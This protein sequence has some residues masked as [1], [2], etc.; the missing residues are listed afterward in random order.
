MT[1]NS[2]YELDRS[3]LYLCEI[4]IKCNVFCKQEQCL[5]LRLILVTFWGFWVVPLIWQSF[6]QKGEMA[7]ITPA[8]SSAKLGLKDFSLTK[9]SKLFKSRFILTGIGEATRM[10]PNS[11]RVYNKT[12]PSE[13]EKRRESLTNYY[14]ANDASKHLFAWLKFSPDSLITLTPKRKSVTRFMQTSLRVNLK[15]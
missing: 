9:I 1:W 13:K 5:N 3:N 6:I 14:Y 10:K 2:C 15:Y 7:C 8:W 12:F 11:I 4:P